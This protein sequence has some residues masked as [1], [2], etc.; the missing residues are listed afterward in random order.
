MDDETLACGG[1]LL[2][3]T[4]KPDIYCLFA[5]DGARSPAPLLPWA[6][7]V[8]PDLGRRR[9]REAQEVAGKI[10][11]PAPNLTFLDLP[12]GALSARSEEL[13]AALEGVLAT[14]KPEL[15]LAPFRYDVHPDHTA[16]NVAARRSL[17]AASAVPMLLEYFVYHRLRYV[18][19]GD[20]RLALD[21]AA[22]LVVDTA[23]VAEA[24]RALLE[25]YR[26]QTTVLYAWQE[27]PILTPESLQR[28]C[29][30]PEVFLPADPAGPMSAGFVSHRRQ[31]QFAC[32]ATRFGKRPK[33]RTV[34]FLRWIRAR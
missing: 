30:E 34:A 21:A 19:G 6:G 7:R 2:L 24:K 22:L 1:T 18:P 16:L 27:R 23:P 15:V 29:S 3:H 4:S 14:I 25:C 5:T 9:R 33:D 13:V 8:D 31:V 10:G 26:S 11:I 32:L 17:R 28:R 20:V 12:D